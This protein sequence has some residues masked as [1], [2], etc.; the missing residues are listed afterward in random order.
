MYGIFNYDIADRRVGYKH[1]DHILDLEAVGLSGYFSDL[2]ID[3]RVFARPVLNDFIALGKP[4]WLAVGTRIRRL[5]AHNAAALANIR[6]Q[7]LIHES[8]ATLYLPVHIGNYTDFYAGIH[9][10]EN[11]G[12]MFRPGGDA[13]LPNYRHLPVAYHGRASSIVV[14]G[15]PIRRP[16]GQTL[17]PNGQPVFG[18][19]KTLDIELELGLII[20]K[21]NPLG[22]PVSVADAE[23]HIF[24]VTLFN[25]WSARDIQRWEYQPLGPFLGKNFGSSMSAW[26]VPLH[27]LEPFRVAGPIQQPEPLPYLQS[28]KPDRWTAGHFDLELEIV[29]HTG[30]DDVVISRT[31][32]RELYWSFAQMV[33]HHTVNGCN[34]QIGDVL[35]TG[36]ISG[37]MPGSYGSLLELSENGTRPLHLPN[38][39][40]RTFLND[41]D[42]VT[43]RGWGVANGLRVDLGDVHGNIIPALQPKS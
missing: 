34:L 8:L 24:G 39:D 21:E 5:L 2:G 9:H 38:G 6:D 19:S 25:D 26:V 4:A 20:G 14:S 23:D 30:A 40:T 7:V 11:V 12:R 18:P 29:L 17:G 10:A 35:A 36:T 42:A 13:L 31:N 32:A 15:T 41:G 16:N 27:D 3:G 43:L 33:A 1:S 37:D 28:K 22:E